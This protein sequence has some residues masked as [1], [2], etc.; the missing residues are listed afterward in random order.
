MDNPQP[1]FNF[2]ALSFD[3]V[4]QETEQLQKQPSKKGKAE[5]G[6]ADEDPI[7]K[8]LE[9]VLTTQ[10][11]LRERKAQD[12][13]FSD[14]V[15]LQNDNAIIFPHTINVIQ[16][17]AGSHK[18]R[19]AEMIVA[20]IIK[21]PDCRHELL[22]I[23]LHPFAAKYTAVYS[24]TERNLTEQLPFA[25]QSIQLKAGY[26]KADH[27]ANF[28]YLSLLQ[29]PRKYRFETLAKYLEQLQHRIS[30]PLFIVLDV[31]T[32]CI[33]D[34][35]KVDKSMELIDLMNIAINEHDVIFLCL[36]HENPKS[37]K[38]RGHFGTELM[39]KAS[40]V[41]QVGFEKDASQNDTD[42]IRVKYLKCRSTA[43]HTPFYM[44]YSD[45]AKGLVLADDS[46]VAGLINTR[47]HK[48]PAEDM[49]EH[50]EM[51]LGDGSKMKRRE[52]MDRL[53]K[54]FGAKDRTIDDRLK[55]IVDSE[56]ELYDNEGNSCWLHKEQAQKEILY[57]L[58]PAKPL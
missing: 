26:A 8:H 17:P 40:T 15:L 37:D 34:F 47:K 50:I 49:I 43:R 4:K 42:L 16:G 48:A 21:L 46:E 1:N 2:G 55:S 39:N 9:T 53:C 27:P 57:S 23:T 19:L 41:M 56:M 32:D 29:V 58:K 20:A 22:N 14:P 38:A 10:A 52:L 24:D 7:E 54:E 18:S 31:S 11:V 25:L 3:E 35:N 28:E 6:K 30:T 45:A 13:K 5:K 44:K 12:I 51:Y 33:E 36:I